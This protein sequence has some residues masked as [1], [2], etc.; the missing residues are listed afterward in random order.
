MVRRSIDGDAVSFSSVSVPIVMAAEVGTKRVARRGHSRSQ[1]D[2]IRHGNPASIVIVVPTAHGAMAVFFTL[3][4]SVCR[5]S[6]TSIKSDAAPL[7][8]C[9]PP[10][11]VG[12]D[13]IDT[14]VNAVRRVGT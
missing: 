9:P 3:T 12:C 2:A 11:I 6:T 4:D 1:E 7:M 5:P 14:G 8:N 10:T 13:C